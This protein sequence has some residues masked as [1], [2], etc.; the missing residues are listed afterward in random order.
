MMNLP[1]EANNKSP[2][3][4]VRFFGGG[5][6]MNS[7]GQPTISSNGEEEPMTN[8]QRGS[9]MNF[10]RGP[11]LNFRKVKGD[12]PLK[13]A[14]NELRC[15]VNLWMGPTT[16][17]QRGPMINLQSESTTKTPTG[18]ITANIEQERRWS[19]MNFRQGWTIIFQRRSVMNVPQGSAMKAPESSTMNFQ[20][21]IWSNRD[22]TNSSILSNSV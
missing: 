18:I 13:G 19:I 2:M 11:M 10:Q 6:L 16:N 5:A 20:C 17:F 8:F 9:R 12:E 7:Q 14:N 22:K 21:N 15:M 4:E 3:E 1:T